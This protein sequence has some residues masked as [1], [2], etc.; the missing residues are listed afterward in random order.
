LLVVVVVKRWCTSF[1][2]SII[3]YARGLDDGF[4]GG[5]SGWWS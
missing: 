4:L 2:G 3:F 1:I 5:V